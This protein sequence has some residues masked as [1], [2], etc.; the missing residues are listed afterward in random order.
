VDIVEGELRRIRSGPGVE[1]E[2]LRPFLIRIRFAADDPAAV[3]ACARETMACVVERMDDRPEFARW[4]QLPAS[5]VRRCAPENEPDPSFDV[6]AWLR[7]WRAMTPEQKVAADAGPWSLSDWLFHFDPTED[8]GRD[9]G[10]WWWDAGVGT[11]GDGWLEV[12][13]DGWPFGS[14]SLFWLIRG[15]GGTDPDYDV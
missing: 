10:W 15:S 13:T 1:D 6:E 5:F 14:G 3:I 8:G 7:E 9:R 2:E 12:A 11:S 4:P